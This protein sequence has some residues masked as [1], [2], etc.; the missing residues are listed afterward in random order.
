[1]NISSNNYL[2]ISSRASPT[3]NRGFPIIDEVR[4]TTLPTG[5]FAKPTMVERR[6]FSPSRIPG[7]RTRRFLD[8]IEE[9]KM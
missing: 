7:V 5:N 1:M 9:G 3:R 2:P 8:A 4:L 6:L